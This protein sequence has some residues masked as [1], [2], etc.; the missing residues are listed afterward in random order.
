MKLSQ[1]LYQDC[2]PIDQPQETLRNAVNTVYS[3]LRGANTN[4]N[5]VKEIYTFLGAR[6]IAYKWLKD[7]RVVLVLKGNKDNDEI[8]NLD[9]ESF[10]DFI[11]TNEDQVAVITPQ[12]TFSQIIISNNFN[13]SY[14]HPPRLVVR[15]NYKGEAI[16]IMTDGINSI[17]V[18]NID[19]IQIPLKDKRPI[20]E[21]LLSYLNLSP[22][23]KFP[24]Y[25][26]VKGAA[27][28]I[29]PTGVYY[30]AVQYETIEGVQSPWMNISRPIS[31]SKDSE[32]VGSFIPTGSEGNQ[33]SGKAIEITITNIDPFYDFYRFA[34]ISIIDGKTSAIQT[35][36]TNI[37]NKNIDNSGVKITRKYTGFE[38]V[39][40]I[41]LESIL[42]DTANYATAEDITLN[43]NNLFLAGPTIPNIESFQKYANNIELSWTIDLADRLSIRTSENSHKNTE[44]LYF[45]QPWKTNEV[46]A[47]YIHL[48][49]KNGR[50]SQGFHIPGRGVESRQFYHGGGQSFFS[51]DVTLQSLYNNTGPLQGAQVLKDMINKFGSDA[52]YFQ[53]YD[54]SKNASDSQNL[55]YWENQNE[56]YPNTEAFETW[57]PEGKIDSKNLQGQKVRHHKMPSWRN[58][59][60][61]N[62]SI[63]NDV[64][65]SAVEEK[66]FFDRSINIPLNLADVENVFYWP[67]NQTSYFGAMPF[68]KS[69]LAIGDWEP[70]NLSTGTT[71]GTKYVASN[72]ERVVLDFNVVFNAVTAA[73][74]KSNQ[75]WILYLKVFTIDG[76]TKER[77]DRFNSNKGTNSD[78]QTWNASFT[79]A[80][81]K[82]DKVFFLN[83]GDS[84]NIEIFLQDVK[85]KISSVDW[86]GTEYSLDIYNIIP[87]NTGVTG[88]DALAL[89]VKNIYIPPEIKEQCQGFFISYA[90]RLDSGNKTVDA[91][92]LM[93]FHIPN[94]PD[95]STTKTEFPK[96]HPFD[97]MFDNLEPA[98]NLIDFVA[99]FEKN[100]AGTL[101]LADGGAEETTVVDYT[102]SGT[103]VTNHWTPS[104]EEEKHVHV[105]KE[106][107]YLL[108]DSSSNI[109]SAE[110]PTNEGKEK[111]IYSKLTTPLSLSSYYLGH[112]SSAEDG[113]T[114]SFGAILVDLRIYRK[115][116]YLNFETQQLLTTGAV[117]LFN[118]ESSKYYKIDKLYG[119]DTFLNAASIVCSLGTLAD[120]AN[121]SKISPKMIYNY[122]FESAQNWGMRY[123][124]FVATTDYDTKGEEF[125]LR[126]KKASESFWPLNDFE[127]FKLKNAFDAEGA[128]SEYLYLSEFPLNNFYINTDYSQS[129]KFIKAAPY[130]PNANNDNDFP[131]RVVRGVALKA[132]DDLYSITKFLVNDYYEVPK[133]KGKIVAINSAGDYIYIST[134]KELLRTVNN[135]NLQVDGLSVYVGKGDV[136]AGDAQPVVFSEE[137]LIGNSCKMTTNFY[138]GGLLIIDAEQQKIFWVFANEVTEISRASMSEFFQKALK[139]EIENQINFSVSKNSAVNVNQPVGFTAGY[140]DENDRL[141]ITK[142]DYVLTNPSKFKGSVKGKSLQEFSAGDIVIDEEGNIK[143]LVIDPTKSNLFGEGFYNYGTMNIL[144]STHSTNPPI[145]TD[146]IE[147]SGFSTSVYSQSQDG[148]S[149][150]YAIVLGDF[151][152]SAYVN[153][154]EFT[155]ENNKLLNYAS[156]YVFEMKIKHNY[157]SMASWVA[158]ANT[159]SATDPIGIMNPKFKLAVVNQETPSPISTSHTY[160]DLT[161]SASNEDDEG[162]ITVRTIVFVS[163]PIGGPGLGSSG[164]TLQVTP[165]VLRP[166]FYLQVAGVQRGTTKINTQLR[167]YYIDEIT[168]YPVLGS[169][170]ILGLADL[171][172]LQFE[173]K[174]MTISYDAI[175]KKWAS[176]HLYTPNLFV[177]TRKNLF[178]INNNKYFQHNV[179]DPGVFYDG[180][181]QESWVE[182][183]INIEKDT[184]KVLASVNWFTEVFNKDGV[185][186]P[187]ETFTKIMIYTADKNTGETS[188]VSEDEVDKTVLRKYKKDWYFNKIRSKVLD[189]SYPHITNDY[190]IPEVVAINISNSLAALDKKRFVDKYFIVRLY[191]NNNSKNKLYL[192]NVQES[193]R[194]H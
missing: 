69:G 13:F 92:S 144:K 91:Q 191:F 55:G 19:N 29:L 23:A 50:V 187:D 84:L 112:N 36:K 52:R 116:V 30:I 121:S 141:I 188:L 56:Y 120:P 105:V 10:K 102:E 2:L 97:L 161:S 130:S 87:I 82:F 177:T 127:D 57:G 162:F 114:R 35:N 182:Y 146:K 101:I 151:N 118:S 160:F 54:T 79:S 31:L 15:Y 93:F 95:A 166:R 135:R 145:I 44:T 113:G 49:Y 22:D 51:E 143:T 159:Y 111:N 153:L 21:N 115:D 6:V 171:G 77:T 18:L 126:A 62:Y 1:G 189:P 147:F 26:S 149:K 136:F 11:P 85:N 78:T 94:E 66:E 98:F 104:K 131:Y 80:D 39:K 173:D 123:S 178:A 86:Q 148:N 76:K 24:I 137:G 46:Y 180:S 183:V 103:Q 132:E 67:A 150:A 169:E 124:K 60:K 20:S 16:V 106:A 8:E 108:R 164:T 175:Q 193:I 100:S 122:P 90:D 163:S 68:F 107:S 81:F 43:N 155:L 72:Q 75:R 28:G 158:A 17:K 110:L 71:V 64:D 40:D 9:S 154:L 59:I 170:A 192:Y 70:I 63:I 181:T 179:G 45:R 42:V 167:S 165:Q 73:T 184:E 27:G 119:G 142:R 41:N 168:I 185:L 65:Q 37:Y 5:G 7:N 190:N 14:N 140:D 138:N 156:T 47:F 38:T 33:N 157:G 74:L 129:A 117:I 88:A 109:L 48:I 133:D 58:L 61:N 25:T 83:P 12:G 96:L 134:E 128:T 89:K 32:N 152:S 3:K 53:I 186:Q 194:L 34:V 176:K 172:P 174:S 99:N 125:R 139:F 4:E